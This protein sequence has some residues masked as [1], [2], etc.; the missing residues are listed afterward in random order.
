MSA[1]WFNQP[2]PARIGFP[3]GWWLR[4]Q[5]FRGRLLELLVALLLNL[6]LNAGATSPG[7]L[8]Q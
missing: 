5:R 1:L 2:Q 4:R 8:G 3:G 6:P 7:R